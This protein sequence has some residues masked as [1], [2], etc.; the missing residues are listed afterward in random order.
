M[1]A[2]LFAALVLVPVGRVAAQL[3]FDGC[4][5]RAG[6]H[7]PG[8]LRDNLPSNFAAEATTENGHPEILWSPHALSNASRYYKILVYIHEC[9]H[10]RLRHIFTIGETPAAERQ[11]DCWAII[12]MHDAELISQIQ[13]DSLMAEVRTVTG[14]ADHLPGDAMERNMQ[15]C[16]ASRTDATAWSAALDSL[17]AAAQTGFRGIV[18]PRITEIKDRVIFQATLNPPGSWDCDLASNAIYRCPLFAAPDQKPAERRYKELAKIARK[19][20]PDGWQVVEQGKGEAP[21]G[22]VKLLILHDTGRGTEFRFVLNDKGEIWLLAA[23]GTG[24]H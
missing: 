11:A 19:W 7:V 12:I 8:V 24:G 14:D 21:T 9:A 6:E 1:R 10:I 5:D 13:E 22:V 4:R 20:A 16:L 3:P 17:A 18:G 2:L 23:P 15:L